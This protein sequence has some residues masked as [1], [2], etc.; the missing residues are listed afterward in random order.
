MSTSETRSSSFEMTYTETVFKN[1][2]SKTSLKLSKTVTNPTSCQKPNSPRGTKKRLI[3]FR[4]VLEIT[5]ED[6]ETFYFVHFLKKLLTFIDNLLYY[7]FF[8]LLELLK[9]ALW[10]LKGVYFFVKPIGINLKKVY[11]WLIKKR[12]PIKFHFPFRNLNTLTLVLD[13]DETLVHCTKEK[14]V[15]KSE[16]IIVDFKGG[17]YE[18]YW[19]SKRPYLEHFIEG[20]SNFYNLMI[21]TS[22]QQEYADTIIDKIDFKRHIK[23]RFYRQNCIKVSNGYIKDLKITKAPLNR[24]IVIDNS[25][26]SFKLNEE[27]AIHIKPWLGTNENDDE[28]EHL[29]IILSGMVKEKRDVRTVLQSLKVDAWNQTHSEATSAYE[30]EF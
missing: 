23:K 5:H 22:S 27:N 18:R 28:L 25:K 3:A 14:P 4:K 21:F 1:R 11:F 19:L 20:M 30:E 16:Q 12:G 8:P 9:L 29:M 15:Y 13:L 6:L 26:L 7:V 17:K 2:Q 10:I 24:T